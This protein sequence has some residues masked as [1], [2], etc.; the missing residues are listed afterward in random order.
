VVCIQNFDQELSVNIHFQDR[1]EVEPEG[2][3][4][5]KWSIRMWSVRTGVD[6]TGSVSCPVA[7]FGIS[8]VEL[9]GSATRVS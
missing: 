9:R 6:G 7:G 8:G 4:T 1:Q 2:G 5:L 3:G